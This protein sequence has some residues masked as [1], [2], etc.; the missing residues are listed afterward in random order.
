[1]GEA[2]P[3]FVGIRTFNFSP[4]HPCVEVRDQPVLEVGI[5][6]L[7]PPLDA[8][9]PVLELQGVLARGAHAL[10][11]ERDKEVDGPARVAA[12]KT[13]G[14]Q[15]AAHDVSR[16]FRDPPPSDKASRPT[17]NAVRARRA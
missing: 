8:F 17:T 10:G 13:H 3:S 6:A 7:Q 14:G 15:C 2:F 5:H 4:H 16:V 11:A 9:T 12:K 1:M